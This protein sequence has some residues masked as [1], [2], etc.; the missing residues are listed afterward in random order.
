MLLAGQA[1]LVGWYSELDEQQL[2]AVFASARTLQARR[3]MVEKFLRAYRRAIADYTVAFLR[4]DAYHKRIIDDKSLKT[5][6]AIARYLYPGRAGESV[7]R[8]VIDAAYFVEPQARLAMP[9]IERQIKWYKD[10]GLIA[11]DV[12]AGAV[13]DAAFMPPPPPPKSHR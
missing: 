6:A 10:Q 13:I 8:A 4:V 11:R 5:A 1:R 9:D 12:V 3:G 2:G 7:N